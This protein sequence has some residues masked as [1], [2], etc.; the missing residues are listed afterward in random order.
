MTAVLSVQPGAGLADQALYKKAQAR[1]LSNP[2]VTIYLGV[3]DAIGLAEAFIPADAKSRWE[4]DIK[5]YVAAFE[6]LSITGSSDP[7]GSHQRV[8]ITVSNP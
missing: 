1:A 5:P 3:R 4:S 8:T 7:S 6:A 2:Q